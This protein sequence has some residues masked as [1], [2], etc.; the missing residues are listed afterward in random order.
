MKQRVLI[1]LCGIL[2]ICSVKAQ[3]VALKTNLLYDATATANLGVEVGL[4]P[5]WTLDVSGNLNAWNINKH[6][7][8]HWLVQPEAR[9]WLCERF[10]GH[11]FGLHLLAGQFNFGNL[12]DK[13]HPLGLTGLSS[14]RYQGWMEGV[15]IAYGYSWI[16]AKHWNIEA[17]LGLGWIHSRSDVYPCAE[18]GTKIESGVNHNYVGPTKL[19]VNLIYLF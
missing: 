16:L 11:F 10:Q 2:A 19:A 4:A 9:Y 12:S 14:K 8:R 5:K 15:G 17:E 3:R 18:C 13:L 7:M 1:L 6:R